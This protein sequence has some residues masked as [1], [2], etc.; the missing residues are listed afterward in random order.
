M[1][2]FKPYCS[3]TM[4]MKGKD[5]TGKVKFSEWLFFGIIP[6]NEFDDQF[7]TGRSQEIN[8]TIEDS[9]KGII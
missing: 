1:K 6:E 8:Q 3:S 5:V 2:N 7:G 9:P 4:I